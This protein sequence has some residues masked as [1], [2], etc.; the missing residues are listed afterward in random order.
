[1]KAVKRNFLKA[2]EIIQLNANNHFQFIQ[3]VNPKHFTMNDE[4]QLH[5]DYSEGLG[6]KEI[7]ATAIYVDPIKMTKLYDAFEFIEEHTLN[8]PKNGITKREEVA[9]TFK[10]NEANKLLWKIGIQIRPHFDTLLHLS[11]A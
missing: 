9:L 8:F 1:M 4:I 11:I 3:Y 5:F 7:I 10:L 6:A 2:N